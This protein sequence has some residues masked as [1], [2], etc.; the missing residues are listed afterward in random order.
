MSK[1]LQALNEKHLW[2]RDKEAL[3]VLASMYNLDP[4]Q[5]VVA[6]L[7]WAIVV[8]IVK[9]MVILEFSIVEQDLSR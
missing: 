5:I 4:T 9:L 2:P 6:F 3:E 1:D 8:Y 7:S